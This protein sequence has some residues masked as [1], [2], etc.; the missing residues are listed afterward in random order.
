MSKVRDIL[1]HVSVEHASRQRKC[2]HNKQHGIAAGEP[3][4]VIKNSQNLGSKGY[5]RECATE[6]INTARAKI[7]SV[8]NIIR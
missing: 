1:S 4:L 7:D 6:I 3:C 2:Y 5:C 8:C